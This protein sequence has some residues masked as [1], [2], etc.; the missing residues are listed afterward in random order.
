[1]FYI[2]YEHVR[3]ELSWLERRADETLRAHNVLGDL[4]VR[5]ERSGMPVDY[6]R[7]IGWDNE[8]SE[9]YIHIFIGI[10]VHCSY[11]AVN[12]RNTVSQEQF[13]VNV[14]ADITAKFIAYENPGYL[15]DAVDYI[16]KILKMELEIAG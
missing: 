13:G 4:L 6:I 1:M 11:G 16:W 10:C 9:F 2:D 7:E 14:R 3:E 12:V 8:E 5:L 15:D